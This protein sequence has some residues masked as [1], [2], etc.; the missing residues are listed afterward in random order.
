MSKKVKALA[1]YEEEEDYTCQSCD[2]EFTLTYHSD[3]GGIIY[4]PEFCPFCGEPLDIEDDEDDI[5]MDINDLTN[6]TK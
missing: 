4:S 2:A 5:D 1:D 3:Q 6:D